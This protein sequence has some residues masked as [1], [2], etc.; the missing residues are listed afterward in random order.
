MTE[1]EEKLLEETLADLQVQAMIFDMDIDIEA[2]RLVPKSDYKEPF[3]ITNW[4]EKQHGG[5][6]DTQF[7]ID[8]E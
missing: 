5:D 3:W 6:F 2:M 4:K 7:D 8:R 1:T